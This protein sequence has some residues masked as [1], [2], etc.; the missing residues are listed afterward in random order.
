M[1]VDI[2]DPNIMA[3]FGEQSVNNPTS[4]LLGNGYVECDWKDWKF[5][6]ETMICDL[7]CE[8]FLSLRRVFIRKSRSIILDLIVIR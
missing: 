5:G 7:Y 3:H 2:S 8:L 6:Q 4:G 1:V